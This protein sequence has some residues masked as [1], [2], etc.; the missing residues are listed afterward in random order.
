MKKIYELIVFDLDGTLVDTVPDIA[1]VFNHELSAAGY[2]ELAERDYEGIVGWGLRRTLE[3]ALPVTL[4]TDEFEIIRNRIV[5]A[6]SENPSSRSTVYPGITEL[7]GYLREHEVP[8]IIY[9]NKAERVACLL[10]DDLFPVTPFR[11]VLG[12]NSKYPAKPDPAALHAWIHEEMSGAAPI[13]F[14]G[15]TPIDAETA[16]RAGVEFAAAGWGYRSHEELRTAGCEKIH[17]RP[18]DLYQ[19]LTQRQEEL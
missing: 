8:M 18:S 14:V 4:L 12:G 16:R 6:Y 2:P 7:L 13:L 11:T 5:R 19:W 15:D 17:D 10:V 9:T 1:A 3:L